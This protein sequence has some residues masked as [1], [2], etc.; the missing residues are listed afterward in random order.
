[1][2]ARLL[3]SIE[4]IRFSHCW[5]GRLWSRS[6]QSS[7]STCKLLLRGAAAH[8][9][10]S[11]PAQASELGL[12]F[13]VLDAWP[14]AYGASGRNAGFL[15]R[16][17]AHNF[18]AA[19]QQYGITAAT[20]M[21]ALS[22]TNQALLKA[23]GVQQLPSY[24]AMPSC[25]LALDDDEA[26]QLT[27]SHRLM[28]EAG[29][30]AT[31][32]QSGT[33]DVWRQRTADHGARH[34]Y[35]DLASRQA[36][37]H[38]DTPN[39]TRPKLGLLNPNDGIVNPQELMAL[40]RSKVHPSRLHNGVRVNGLTAYAVHHARGCCPATAT[41]TSTRSAGASAAGHPMAPG[42]YIQVHIDGLAAPLAASRV[43]VATNAYASQLLPQLQGV[44]TPHR[45]QMLAALPADGG[46]LNLEYS[47]YADGGDK[48][49]R[50]GPGGQLLL[51]GC[52]R[53]FAEQ[54][55]TSDAT[56]SKPVQG[57]LRD[58]AQ[59][60]FGRDFAMQGAWAGT[61]GFSPSGLP[62]VGPVGVSRGGGDDDT[63]L[64]ERVW[65]AGGFTG[66]GMS[67]GYVTGRNAVDGM[68]GDDAAIP[69]HMQLRGVLPQAE[70]GEARGE[71]VG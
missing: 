57:A 28:N 49:F 38:G 50:P 36:Y 26:A 40:L 1:M 66:H 31:L 11:P 16:G 33:D 71:A 30:P 56:P 21:W 47:Y 67:L 18:H 35:E 60:L 9:E 23:A 59:G 4:I 42:K 2:V 17:V 51:G 13:V 19:T 70:G 25:L 69:P 14:P 8:Q 15:I 52:R 3:T 24:R 48:Y 37:E 44:V 62:V 63:E 32:I 58:F 45:A 53:E 34:T 10:D 5:I 43:L 6:C 61:M 46:T 29:I 64:E 55:A 27:S 7:K 20:S 39:P 41:A 22:E 68:L 12:N 65:F 54:E